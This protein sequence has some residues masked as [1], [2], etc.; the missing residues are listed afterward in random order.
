MS[1]LLLAHIL[2]SSLDSAAGPNWRWEIGR[3]CILVLE[4]NLL[5]IQV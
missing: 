3:E 4:V 5:N 2:G 1:F